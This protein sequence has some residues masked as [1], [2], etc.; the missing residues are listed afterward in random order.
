MLLVVAGLAWSQAI[1]DAAAAIAGGSVGGA[2]GKKVSDGVSA[3]IRRRWMLRRLRRPRLRSPQRPPHIAAEKPSGSTVLQVGSGG[4]GEG[5]LAGAASAPA[6]QE[7]RGSSPSAT[8]TRDAVSVIRQPIPAL[9]PPPRATADDLK[10]LASG[11]ARAEVLKLGAPASRIT[12]YDDGHLVEI[13]R[14][15]SRDTTLGVV[16]LSDGTVSSVQVR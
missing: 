7:S 9:P 2:A 6:G 10:T 12:M 11:T 15:Q 16:R 5:S 8:A 13:Y 1:T 14:Y 3:H 4:G